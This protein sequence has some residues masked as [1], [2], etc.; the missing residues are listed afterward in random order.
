MRDYD[1][2]WSGTTQKTVSQIGNLRY[3]TSQWI[4]NDENS[5]IAL[6]NKSQ[7]Y[8]FKINISQMT[9]YLNNCTIGTVPLEYFSEYNSLN[10]FC[11]DFRSGLGK[12]SD[13]AGEALFTWPVLATYRLHRC[14]W[15][16]LEKCVGYRFRMWVTDL[17]HREIT[18][19]AKKGAN[20]M[21]LPTTSEMSH[22]HKVTNITMSPTSLSSTYRGYD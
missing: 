14:W 17:I 1:Q 12:P 18:N 10:L 6:F 2:K 15:R 16:M 4:N 21:I 3:A 9:W 11:R 13:K 20:I 8:Q 19:I 5:E 22:H 7:V